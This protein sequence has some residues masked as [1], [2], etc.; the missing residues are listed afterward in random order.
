MIIAKSIPQ[1]NGRLLLVFEGPKEIKSI[2]ATSMFDAQRIV[3]FHNRKYILEKMSSWLHQRKY[4]MSMMAGTEERLKDIQAI[5]MGLAYRKH[6]SLG[7]IC[8][9]LHLVEPQIRLLI[10]PV[11]SAHYKIFYTTILPILR[12]ATGKE[13]INE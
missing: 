4:A 12:F 8:A 10:P 7:N 5:E 6:A 2:E 11:K 9:Y 1:E 13:I 3:D